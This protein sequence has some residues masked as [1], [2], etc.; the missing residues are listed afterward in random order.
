MNT[1][2]TRGFSY[3]DQP[4]VSEYVREALR[5]LL[6]PEPLKKGDGDYE[7]G[8]EATKRDIKASLE[9]LLGYTL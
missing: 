3:T 4:L 7:I 6:R 2:M 1:P 5:A 8:V 9:A